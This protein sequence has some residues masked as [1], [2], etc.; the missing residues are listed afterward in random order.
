MT[1]ETLLDSLLGQEAQT[2]SCHVW[3]LAFFDIFEY[4][5]AV[6]TIKYDHGNTKTK[7]HNKVFTGLGSIAALEVRKPRLTEV[8]SRVPG[9]Q[10]AAGRAG[11]PSSPGQQIRGPGN[12]VP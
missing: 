7:R 1:F 8:T 10:L 5:A 11:T 3:E 2:R 9:A 6:K 4:R 12:A